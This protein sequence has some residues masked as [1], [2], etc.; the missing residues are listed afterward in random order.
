MYILLIY[1]LLLISIAIVSKKQWYK[2]IF[3]SSKKQ[4]WLWAATSL[5]M[6]N[7]SLDYGQLLYG[8]IH[9]KGIWGAWLLWG[10][11]ITAGFIPIVF[12][13]LW[14]KLDFIT[15]NQ[16]ILKRF[17]GIGGRILHQF[18]AIYVGGMVVSLLLSFQIIAFS[19]ILNVFT[20]WS[21]T[22]SLL[23]TGTTLALYALKN[24]MHIKFKN[25]M[26]HAI[27]YGISLIFML[28]FLMQPFNSW[29]TVLKQVTLNNTNRL[30]VFPE[31]SQSTYIYAIVVYLGV[32]WWSAQ[33]FDGGGPEMARFTAVKKPIDAIKVGLLPVLLNIVMVS[34]MLCIVL[35]AIAHNP[36]S[37]N[38]I[39]F[40]K[41][42]AIAVPEGLHMLILL[43]FF[44]L[45]IT[46]SEA[47]L[48]WGASFL[49]I[50]V[51]KTYNTKQSETKYN[52]IGF[53]IMVLLSCFAM[54][55]SYFANSLQQLIK[56]V[57]SISAGVAPVYFLRWFWRRINAWAQLSA[58]ISSGIYTLLFP[59]LILQ[60]DFLKPL[61]AIGYN[62]SRLLIVTILTTLTW[63]AVMYL[64]PK[65]DLEHLSV[66]KKIIPENKHV[67]KSILMALSVGILSITVLGVII[68]ILT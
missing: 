47:L 57:F 33:L 1:L 63:I 39:Q 19:R 8:I 56:I 61:V 35:M 16:F 5:F 66:F 2:S 26:L 53:M 60:F 14:A 27:L 9:E 67:I 32:Q 42:I 49:T 37:A 10:G 58:M 12:A 15:D 43:G 11:F 7:S 30:N 21:Y 40:I 62:E 44:S 3:N 25:D 17:S 51:Y 34:T 24:T 48:N 23:I 52:T 68:T 20:S 64:T 28:Y 45:F 59:Y 38:E 18:R 6:L 4:H 55:I 13:P 36:N 22:T 46:T 31:L 65:D 54:C 29:D 41:T 50:D